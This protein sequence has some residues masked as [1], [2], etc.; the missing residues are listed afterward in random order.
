MTGKTSGF[1]LLLF[2]AI[3]VGKLFLFQNKN[4]VIDFAAK[5]S[6]SE[7]DYKAVKDPAAANKA[8]YE[9]MGREAWQRSRQQA[10]QINWDRGWKK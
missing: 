7:E 2:V 3:V 1:F 9:K 8:Y 5:S 6:L 4:A 10:P